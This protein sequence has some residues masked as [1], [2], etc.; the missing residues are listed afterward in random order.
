MKITLDSPILVKLTDKGLAAFV[1]YLAKDRRER[2]D[3]VKEMG[4]KPFEEGAGNAKVEFVLS[5]DNSIK[6]SIGELHRIFSEY[7]DIEF[8]YFIEGNNIEIL[9]QK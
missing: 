1:R 7:K 5:D 9:E 6:T 8:G 2:R 3:Y 4:G